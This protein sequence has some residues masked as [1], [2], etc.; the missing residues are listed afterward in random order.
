MIIL[1]IYLLGYIA[2]FILEYRYTLNT[3]EEV[4][5]SDLGFFF[6]LS[7]GS[8]ISVITGLFMYYGDKTIACKK[9]KELK[10]TSW[11]ATDKGKV[12]EIKNALRQLEMEYSI[13]FNK[14]IEW[15]ENLKYRI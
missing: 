6:I 9:S 10:K 4:K 7:M 11:T 12:E 2:N 8:W 3:Y 1:L 14:E 5:I 15:L 13:S